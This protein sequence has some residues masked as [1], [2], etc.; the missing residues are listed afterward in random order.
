MQQQGCICAAPSGAAPLAA[1]KACGSLPPHASTHHPSSPLGLAQAE[2]RDTQLFHYLINEWS[3]ESG[4]GSPHGAGAHSGPVSRAEGAVDPPPSDS[5]WLSFSV[6][7]AFRGPL[8][9]AAAR[10]FRDE[11]V[12]NMVGAFQERCAST[13]DEPARAAHARA[14]GAHAEQRA[15]VAQVAAAAA[16]DEQSA[17]AL[18]QLRRGAAEGRKGGRPAPPLPPA[19]VSMW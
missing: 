10:L 14:V 4:P 11:V 17:A 8:Y 9:A 7:F 12:A 19:G 18:A 2:A 3:F 5:T 1:V 13:W 6:E 15:R 16:A